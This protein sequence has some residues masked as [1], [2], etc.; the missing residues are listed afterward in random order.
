[1]SSF[2]G[3]TA[4]QGALVVRPWQV[5]DVG[6]LSVFNQHPDVRAVGE[7]KRN[8]PAHIKHNRHGTPISNGKIHFVENTESYFPNFQNSSG[9][10]N[11]QGDGNE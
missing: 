1:M 2:T 8:A 6:R 9:G 10:N 11:Q 4:L 3:K 5:I 7:T